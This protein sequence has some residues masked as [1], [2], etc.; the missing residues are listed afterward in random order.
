MSKEIY[1]EM[2]EQLGTEPIEAEIPL[3]MDDFPIEVQDAIVVY[4]KLR[5]EW[6]SMSGTYL[7]KSYLG[8]RDILDLYEIDQSNRIYVLDWISVMDAARSKAIEAKKPKK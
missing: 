6:D 3:D 1:F 4:Y 7:G 8:L 5:D 2:C